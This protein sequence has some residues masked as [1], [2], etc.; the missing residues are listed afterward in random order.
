L[1]RDLG[2]LPHEVVPA[3]D[4][5]VHAALALAQTGDQV[6]LSPACA[7][8]DQFDNFEQRGERFEALVADWS[9]AQGDPHA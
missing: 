2:D 7:S 4:E 6:L 8:F 1:K 3:F 5:A 9:K